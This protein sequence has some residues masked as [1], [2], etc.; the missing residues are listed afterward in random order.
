[1]KAGL[2]GI[3]MKGILRSGDI[4]GAGFFRII[5]D[6]C[7]DCVCPVRNFIVGNG[8]NNRYDFRKDMTNYARN[9]YNE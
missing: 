6:V 8:G 7:W 2:Y 9:L 1:M 3:S 5:N 4:G